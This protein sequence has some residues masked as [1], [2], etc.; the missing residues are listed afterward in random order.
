MEII[1]DSYYISSVAQMDDTVLLNHF[2]SCCIWLLWVCKSQSIWNV[3]FDVSVAAS[4]S[5]H[6]R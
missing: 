3:H 4:R 1:Y 5:S 6:I 2:R